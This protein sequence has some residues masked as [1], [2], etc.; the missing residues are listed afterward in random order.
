MASRSFVCLSFVCLLA[1]VPCLARA[2]GPNPRREAPMAQSPMARSPGV[3]APRGQARP[4]ANQAPV[5]RAAPVDRSRYRYHE[6]RWWYWLP[7][8]R[9]ALW[10]D[11]HW[12]IYHPEAG[13]GLLP[14]PSP[15]PWPR[16]YLDWRGTQFAGRYSPEAANLEAASRR[17]TDAWRKRL[18][19]EATGGSGTK[20]S[21]LAMDGEF[22]TRVDRM[23]DRISITP[24]DYRIGQRGHG[25]FD[26]DPDRTIFNS[27]K[28]NY[29]TS[30]GGY[31]GS[32][33]RGPFGY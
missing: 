6:G 31:M 5:A 25:L 30:S 7:E 19:A 32:A 22:A 4:L 24:Y 28:L 1:V 17:D 8:G 3:V 21:S 13:M 16:A 26:A 18:T 20:N 2:Q 23:Q 29:A 10:A 27:G 12:S 9:W 14:P 15:A 33:L 11:N